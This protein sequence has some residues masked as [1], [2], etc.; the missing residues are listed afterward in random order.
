LQG[1]IASSLGPGPDGQDWLFSAVPVQYAGWA[2]VVQRP[3]SEALAVVAQFHLWLLIAA[4]LFAIGGL[5]FWFMLLVRVIRP[6]HTLAIQHQ[7]LPTSEQS[8]PVQATMLAKRD[9]EVG[10]LAQSLV[11]LER[12]GLKN[13]GE[14]R[15]LLENSNGVVMYL[16]PHAFVSMITLEV[17]W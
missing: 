14:L 4:L 16:E 8:I 2:V 11:R 12:D 5:L 13:L 15:K 1:H 7:A 3:A 10:H 17:Q 6:L 9:D